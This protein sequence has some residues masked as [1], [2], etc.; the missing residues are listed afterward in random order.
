MSEQFKSKCGHCNTSGAGFTAC[1]IDCLSNRGRG[2]FYFI[3]GKCG[4]C[5]SSSFFQCNRW[6]EYSAHTYN[7][8][9]IL[10]SD[11]P[12]GS[13]DKQFPPIQDPQNMGS[14]SYPDFVEKTVIETYKCF[15]AMAWDATISQVRKSVELALGD[16]IEEHAV[17]N[18]ED[19]A[20]NQLDE[21]GEVKNLNNAL[22]RCGE[23]NIIPQYVIDWMEICKSFGN[24]STHRRDT[25]FDKKDSEEAIEFMEIILE[26]LY[27][28]PV[29]V[30]RAKARWHSQTENPTEE[31]EL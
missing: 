20:K 23:L 9:N 11:K 5:N 2:Y 22:K 18:V 15:H 25:N 8:S 1:H 27:V 30:E 21:R 26:Y 24:D 19:N 14:D 7:A 4:V 17:T 10:Y 13:N 31:S 12:H 16:V 6:E 3:T 28:M 29:R